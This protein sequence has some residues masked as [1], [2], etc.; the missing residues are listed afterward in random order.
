MP[1][2][3]LRRLAAVICL[4]SV[5][6]FAHAD[7]V[8]TL[9]LAFADLCVKTPPDFDALREKAKNLQLPIKPAERAGPTSETAPSSQM[10][11]LE[12]DGETFVL[13]S[14]TEERP[15]AGAIDYCQIAASNMR[16]EDVREALT[17]L[18]GLDEPAADGVMKGT[19]DK[20]SEQITMWRKEV[21]RSWLSIR[22]F[23]AAAG[24]FEIK[25]VSSRVAKFDCVPGQKEM[26]LSMAGRTGSWG[27]AGR[28]SVVDG[29]TID[30]CGINVSLNDIA[31]P[32]GS[33]AL[34]LAAKQALADYIGDAPVNCIEEGKQPEDRFSGFCLVGEGE[35]IGGLMVRGGFA[36]ACAPV[37]KKWE[38]LARQKKIGIWA[39]PSPPELSCAE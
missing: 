28:A 9:V 18:L 7:G 35:S 31:A 19:G 11:T 16:G 3:Q 8:T 6:T 2:R 21:D 34:S 20:P 24:P 10:W 39:S 12:R 38:Q 27:V 30:L 1:R 25:L 4:L 36:K 5:S 32:S 13:A 17:K 22:L 14:A 33:D 23:Y 26:M 15:H 29:Q 37:H